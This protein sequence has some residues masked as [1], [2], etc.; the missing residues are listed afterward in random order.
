[1]LDKVLSLSNT[2]KVNTGLFTNCL[3]GI[4]D[5]SARR[6]PNDHTNS[7]VFLAAHLVEARH[8]LAS[9]LNVAA[10]TP[11]D[12]MLTGAQAIDDITDYPTLDAIRA[13]WDEITDKLV[14][15]FETLT[16][17]ELAV[18]SKPSFPGDD[19]TILGAMAFLIQHE[20]YH[21]GQMAFIR[22]FFE[23][24]PMSYDFS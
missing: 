19:R 20:A 12:G 23:R 18:T 22:K 24:G 16:D 17:E 4:D 21:I 15:R 1:M 14:S 2:M 13:A 8:F 9:Q 10:A 7:M 5:E 6:R 3:E 11:F